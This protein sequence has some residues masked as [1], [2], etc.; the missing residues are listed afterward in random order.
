MSAA[1]PLEPLQAVYTLAGDESYVRNQFRRALWDCLP[2]SAQAFG[3]MEEDLAETPLEAILDSARN[4]SLMAPVQVFWLRNARELFARGTASGDDNAPAG[5]KKHGDF[6]ANLAA[7]AAQAGAPA[8]AVVVFV[9]DHLHLPAERARMALEDKSRLQRIETTLGQAGPLIACAQPSPVQ[10]AALAQQ[11]AAGQGCTLTREQARRLAE[12]CDSSLEL[13][14]REVE[15][16]AI[17]TGNGAVTDAALTA[18]AAGSATASAYELAERI[19]EGKRAAALLSLHRWLR[20]E[21]SSGAIGLIFQLSRAFSMALIVRQERVRDRSSLYRVLPE[22]LRPPGFAADTV[23][24]IA[25]RMSEA[26]LRRAIP[27]LH[28]TDVALRSSPPSIALVLEQ[29]VTAMSR[30]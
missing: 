19:A 15:K 1:F 5:K 7:F 6:P 10:A 9:A 2:E 20:D 8:S 11:M 26:R 21:G 14:Q 28:R 23:L 18:L 24:G 29:T 30:P 3:W 13:V 12:L 4:P 22:G 27:E 17:Y 16:L 25:Q